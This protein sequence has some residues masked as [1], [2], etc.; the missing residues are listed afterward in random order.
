MT[1]WYYFWNIGGLSLNE[2]SKRIWMDSLWIPVR[3][4]SPHRGLRIPVLHQIIQ[5][6][7]QKIVK[8]NMQNYFENTS[9]SWLFLVASRV[10]FNFWIFILSLF[11]FGETV[12]ANTQRLIY[13]VNEPEETCVRVCC[14]SEVGENKWCLYPSMP[15]D[16]EPAP[17]GLQLLKNSRFSYQLP[18]ICIF[19]TPPAVTLHFEGGGQES[20]GSLLN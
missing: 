16:R 14:V 3:Y 10:A 7:I 2:E 13:K 17:S 4:R 6:F 18:L 1:G 20:H 5:I 9:Q 12:H 8:K 19:M 11:C 15:G